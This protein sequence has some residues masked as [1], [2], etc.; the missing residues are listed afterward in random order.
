MNKSATSKSPSKAQHFLT[1]FFAPV[2]SAIVAA[3]IGF[4]TSAVGVRDSLIT[5][6]RDILDL[7]G[8]SKSNKEEHQKFLNKEVQAET[9]RAVL[10]ALGDLK[11]RTGRIEQTQIQIL[12]RL[13][14]AST[15]PTV[16]APDVSLPSRVP[17]GR[18]PVRDVRAAVSTFT[19]SKSRA[20]IPTPAL[21]PGD[22]LPTAA[23]GNRQ[24]RRA[25]NAA[26]RRAIRR[27]Y[28][29][30]FMRR[31]APEMCIISNFS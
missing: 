31:V 25:V 21:L 2:A 12:Q 18:A 15:L 28:F 3:I 4:G 9:N 20:A 14:G 22:V 5:I 13:P 17:G 11:N 24:Q 7:K 10:E 16:A 27:T 29:S 26:C 1:Y 6:R 8:D 19:V 30:K 23:P